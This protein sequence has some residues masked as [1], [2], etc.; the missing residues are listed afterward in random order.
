MS[1]VMKYPYPGT[2]WCKIVP[3]ALK[4]YNFPSSQVDKLLIHSSR[5]SKY[6]ATWYLHTTVSFD[7]KLNLEGKKDTLKNS[8]NIASS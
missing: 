2:A 7:K 8:V 5:H 6:N 1:L 3:S 4:Q